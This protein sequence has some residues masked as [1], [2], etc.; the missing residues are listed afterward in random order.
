MVVVVVVAV[1]VVDS[2][3]NY[4][5]F[6][7]RNQNL[8]AQAVFTQDTMTV[9]HLNP[10]HCSIVDV[11]LLVSVRTPHLLTLLTGEL[12]SRSSES[13]RSPP[14]D[15]HWERAVRVISPALQTIG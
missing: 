13:R 11:V 8:H 3:Y 9:F 15:S 2:S 10:R 4:W 5:G 6:E 1:V 7:N 14:R 12:I